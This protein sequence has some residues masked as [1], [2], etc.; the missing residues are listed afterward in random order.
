MLTW[1]CKTYE[2]ISTNELWALEPY[3]GIHNTSAHCPCVYQ[4][5]ALLPLQFLRKVEQNF[6]I[7]GKLYDLS[8]VSRDVTPRVIGPLALIL[9]YMLQQPT[10]HVCVNFQL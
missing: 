5:S 6:F 1:Q 8:T 2:G 9:V 10:V 3:S 7:N 4:V